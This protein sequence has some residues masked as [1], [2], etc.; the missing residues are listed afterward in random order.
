MFLLS[1]KKALETALLLRGRKFFRG[2]TPVIAKGNHLIGFYQ[3]PGHI[4]EPPVA[5]Y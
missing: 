4:T 1:N 2:T 5:T 3:I